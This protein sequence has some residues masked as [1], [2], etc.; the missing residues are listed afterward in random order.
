MRLPNLP[1]HFWQDS[2][3]EAIGDALGDFILVDSVSS[4]VYRT[5][6][7]R[8]LVEMDISKGLPEMLKL[9]SPNGSW[10]QLLDYEG[11]PFRC[12]KCHKTGHLIACCS[13]DKASSKKSPSWW[14]GV[15]D[16]QYIV[17][18]VSMEVDGSDSCSHIDLSLAKDFVDVSDDLNFV[19]T[20]DLN[21]NVASISL[22]VVVSV[23][24][25]FV[26]LTT[27]GHNVVNVPF[28]AIDSV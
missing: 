25:I 12:K 9:A 17:H 5:T 8:I 7:A 19:F 15:P 11:I 10:I 24:S 2:V 26:P 23:D 16:D 22:L 18:K 14:L 1:L 27:L 13:S 3:L 28:F 6:F 4:N 20:T 21:H